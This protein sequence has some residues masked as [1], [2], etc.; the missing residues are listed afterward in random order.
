MPLVNM[1]MQKFANAIQLMAFNLIQF[2]QSLHYKY[3]QYM[4]IPPFS[5][6]YN[7][8]FSILP[9][10]NIITSVSY[11]EILINMN[12]KRTSILLIIFVMYIVCM[13]RVQVEGAR[14]LSEDFSQSN[15]L[16]TIPRMYDSARETM[17]FWIQRL[18]SGPSPRGPG[19]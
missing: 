19:H 6:H 17:S 10:I 3:N 12:S 13:S 15:R 4:H 7:L 1:K 5:I 16:V 2:K 14:I 8:S 9:I 11:F 18:A